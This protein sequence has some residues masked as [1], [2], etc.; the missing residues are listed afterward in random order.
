[1]VRGFFAVVP[2]P[3]MPSSRI[4]R[5]TVHRGHP[6]TGRLQLQ[7]DLPRPIDAVARPR[8]LQSRGVIGLEH[9]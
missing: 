9:L 8:L 5:S 1:V 4:S 3:A 6:N 7:Q 2:T